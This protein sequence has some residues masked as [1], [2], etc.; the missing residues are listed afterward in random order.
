MYIYQQYDR[1]NYS[2]QSFAHVDCVH[3]YFT[4]KVRLKFYEE[5]YEE[6]N[7]ILVKKGFARQFKTHF[8]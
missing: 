4:F 6:L 2:N 1:T 3:Q 7:W 8:N 5:V